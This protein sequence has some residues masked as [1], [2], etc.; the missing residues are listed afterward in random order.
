MPLKALWPNNSFSLMIPKN[1]HLAIRISLEWM[2]FILLF[3][4]PFPQ[5]CCA[6]ASCHA[7]HFSCLLR[8][9]NGCCCCCVHLIELSYINRD[10]NQLMLF[11]WKLSL[12]HAPHFLFFKFYF[13]FSYFLSSNIWRFFPNRWKMLTA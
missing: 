8:N 3:S 9:A 11:S 1:Q 13:V 5:N 4:Y 10:I 12:S 2:I 7:T 6:F